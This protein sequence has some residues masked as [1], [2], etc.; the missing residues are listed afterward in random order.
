MHPNAAFRFKPDDPA[1]AFVVAHGFANIFGMTPDG[2][3]V[4]HAPLLVMPSG[5]LRFHLANMNA[6]APHLD[7]EPVLASIG[8]PGSYI[9]PNWYADPAVHVPTWNYRTVEI[10]GTVRKLGWDD[11]GDLLDQSAATFEPRVG[12]NWTMAKMARPRAEAMMKSITAFELAPDIIRAT[13]KHSQNRSEADARGV[14][15]ALERIGDTAGAAAIRRTRG[16]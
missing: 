10:E 13:D 6:L 16:W 14:V 9:S 2:P 8:G 4:A 1:L 12:E 15:D 11:L 5:T 7:G 3:R